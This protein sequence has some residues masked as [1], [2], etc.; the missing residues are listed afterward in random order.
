[1]NQDMQRIFD[2]GLVPVVV[3]EDAR[4]AVPAARAL[5]A[6]GIDVI[7][8]TMR[9]GAGLQAIENISRDCPEM[10]VAAGTV[11]SVEKCKDCLAAG[12]RGIVSPGFDAAIVEHCLEQEAMAFPGCVTP[13]EIQRAMAYDLQVL[14]FFPANVYGGLEALKALA[15][16]FERVSF[17]PTGGV[18]EA[19]VGVFAALA[20]VFAIGG[21]WV[22]TRGDIA[23]GA[24]DKI[25]ALSAR[26]RQ[27]MMGFEF[28]HL[29]INAESAEASIQVVQDLQA[30]FGFPVKPG[31]S[32][33][34]A[35]ESLEVTK[36]PYLG[37]HGHVAIRT[38][39]VQRAIA[40]LEAKGYATDASTAR[41]KNELMVAVYLK[42]E[43]AGF[44]VHLLQK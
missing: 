14:K 25:T 15:G 27:A 9:T 13:T 5:Q 43:V 1:M 30:L 12:A 24:F 36:G 6:G 42:D 41:F 44:A 31:S 21:S 39:N 33:N 29:G 18:N 17:I 40:Y 23:A 3:I 10:L 8:I 20:N 7:E 11:L 19:N 22:C 32:S 34:F 2:C 38:N 26:A 37:A 35:G 16:P 28:A 4:D